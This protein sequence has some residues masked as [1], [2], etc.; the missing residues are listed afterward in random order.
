LQIFASPTRRCSEAFA[1]GRA[2]DFGHAYGKHKIWCV[3]GLTE[4]HTAGCRPDR[5]L[6]VVIKIVDQA[7]SHP[8]LDIELLLMVNDQDGRKAFVHGNAAGLNKSMLDRETPR[9]AELAAPASQ[10]RIA[11]RVS[12]AEG[13]LGRVGKV[14]AVFAHHETDKGSVAQLGSIACNSDHSRHPAALVPA[15]AWTRPATVPGQW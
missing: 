14:G 2:G 12:S 6:A 4:K 5:P 3:I 10:H 1:G 11:E 9:E 8:W 13:R 15:P 7:L